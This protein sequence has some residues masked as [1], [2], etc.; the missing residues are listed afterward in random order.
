MGNTAIFPRKFRKHPFCR[1]LLECTV[2]MMCVSCHVPC[3]GTWND[4]WLHTVSY[5][6]R[7]SSDAG[8]NIGRESEYKKSPG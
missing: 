3:T 2:K 8:F 5:K 7:L 4:F 6:S 1:Q